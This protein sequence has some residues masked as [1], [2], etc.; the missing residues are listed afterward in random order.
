MIWFINT[1]SVMLF[2]ISLAFKIAVLK[3][4]YVYI[5]NY[6]IQLDIYKLIYCCNNFE[7]VV[8]INFKL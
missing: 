5:N 3:I 2:F 7:S 8:T 6:N 1:N 4:F